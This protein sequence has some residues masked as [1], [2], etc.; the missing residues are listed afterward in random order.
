MILDDIAVWGIRHYNAFGLDPEVTQYPSEALARQRVAECHD[1]GHGCVLLS[2]SV[3]PWVVAGGD[4][5]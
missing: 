4:A 3:T 5:A 2:R 1:A